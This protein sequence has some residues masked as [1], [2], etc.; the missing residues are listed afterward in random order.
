[1]SLESTAK[2]MGLGPS[3]DLQRVVLGAW[4]VSRLAQQAEIATLRRQLDSAVKLEAAAKPDEDQSFGEAMASVSLR[5]EE[6][7]RSRKETVNPQELWLMAENRTGSTAERRARGRCAA[8]EST[9]TAG[10]GG[11]AAAVAW[12]L[13]CRRGCL[14]AARSACA[15]ARHL[16]VPLDADRVR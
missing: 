10:C 11:V 2:A 3:E 16:Q 9:A 6:T 13:T 14:S 5:L 12:L 8:L 7:E 1:M 15:H 4:R